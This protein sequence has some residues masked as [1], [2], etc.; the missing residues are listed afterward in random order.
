[1][2]P[3]TQ[4]SRSERGTALFLV[5]VLLAAMMVLLGA[6]LAGVNASLA[7]RHA[8]WRDQVTHALAAAGIEYAAA[9]LAEQ[10][11]RYAGGENIGTGEGHVS[12]AVSPTGTPGTYTV[13]STGTI[14][15]DSPMP[16]ETTL[17]AVIRI[18]GARIV[19][20]RYLQPGDASD[21]KGQS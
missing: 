4:K 12:V 5:V 18:D 21:P 10:G 11:S 19:S 7:R 9:H 1:M 2:L 13:R 17:S 6:L 3:T 14:D 15:H 20:I 16:Q 8:D